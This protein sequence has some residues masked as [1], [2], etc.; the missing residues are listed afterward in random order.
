MSVRLRPRRW[1][2]RRVRG[3]V[4]HFVPASGF[5]QQIEQVRKHLSFLTD[6]AVLVDDD[7]ASPIRSTSYLVAIPDG[8]TGV[9]TTFDYREEFRK[10]TGGWLRL[11]YAYELRISRPHGTT[12]HARRAHHDH[13]PWGTHRHCVT[14]SSG[15]DVHYA[16]VERLLQATHELFVQQ[17][18]SGSPIDCFGLVPLTATRSRSGPA[19]S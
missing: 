1:R 4:P 13:P 12:L 9:T 16:D 18:A 7:R 3:S 11:R 2:K 19:S 6:D 5:T 17:F 14:P 10:V 15:E 8:R